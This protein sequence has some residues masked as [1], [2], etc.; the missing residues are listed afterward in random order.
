[1]IQIADNI[2]YQ[3]PKP[4]FARDYYTTKTKLKAVLDTDIDDGHIAYCAETGLHY[5]YKYTNSVDDEIGKWREFKPID[6][7]LS[8]DSENAIQNKVVKGALKDLIDKYDAV[9]D[10]LDNVSDLIEMDSALDATSE[11]GVQNKVLKAQFDSIGVQ[12]ASIINSLGN[13]VKTTDIQTE[14]NNSTNPVSSKAVKTITDSLSTD[15]T[16]INE[17]L[18]N[19]RKYHLTDDEI[20]AIY[21]ETRGAV[22]DALGKTR[23]DEVY[24]WYRSILAGKEDAPEGGIDYSTVEKRVEDLEE[25]LNTVRTTANN[26]NV[27]SQALQ[28]WYASFPADD[29][30]TWGIMNRKPEIVAGENEEVLVSTSASAASL[31]LES[32]QRGVLVTDGAS[33]DMIIE[34]KAL[35]GDKIFNELAVKSIQTMELK[36]QLTI[37]EQLEQAKAEYLNNQKGQV[38]NSTSQILPLPGGTILP[39]VEKPDN[40]ATL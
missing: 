8:D 19:F 25:N 32:I 14:V 4:N 37:E 33:E 6:A 34:M 23:F 35:L 31:A 20:E 22:V 15:I 21:K 27:I 17:Q 7:V 13:C 30:Q 29:N 28:D 18:D 3:G 39:S 10:T 16:N 5:E 26:A 12:I 40:T 36:P 11:R 38:E 9:K 24:D 1:M 2:G